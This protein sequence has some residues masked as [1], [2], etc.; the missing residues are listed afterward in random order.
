MILTRST[1]R[2][3]SPLMGEGWDGG[4][5]MI[6]YWQ[7]FIGGIATGW[8]ISEASFRSQGEYIRSIVIVGIIGIVI[9][10]E[11]LYVQSKIRKRA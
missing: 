3:P 10:V 11:K 6:L 7:N 1:I 9:S 8:A 4:D 5:I 2:T